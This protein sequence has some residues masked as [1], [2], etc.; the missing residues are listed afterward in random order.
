MKEGPGGG[1][2]VLDAINLRPQ[3]G[4]AWRLIQ[5]RGEDLRCCGAAKGVYQGD[6]EDGGGRVDPRS[7]ADLLPRGG[8]VGADEE[9]GRASILF[10][11]PTRPS[12]CSA[13]LSEPK[14]LFISWCHF[15]KA[16]LLRFFVLRKE[17]KKE[18]KAARL[19]R[20]PFVGW[21][22]FASCTATPWLSLAQKQN[23]K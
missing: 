4:T 9:S 17:R 10:L 5:D 7:I 2:G 21:W 13:R 3:R 1:G 12:A 19:S 11:L 15:S 6:A 16:R 8:G 22:K 18:R 14:L 23:T 20:G